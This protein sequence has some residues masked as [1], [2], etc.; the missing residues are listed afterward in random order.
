MTLDI[1]VTAANSICATA[2]PAPAAPF[3]LFPPLAFWAYATEDKA[4]NKKKTWTWIISFPFFLSRTLLCRS[5]VWT[6][7]IHNRRL[8]DDEEWLWF[9]AP[10]QFTHATNVLF[11]L[12]YTHTCVCVS[13]FFPSSDAVGPGE[14]LIFRAFRSNGHHLRTPSAPVLHNGRAFVYSTRFVF[15]FVEVE[16]IRR[17]VSLKEARDECVVAS[18]PSLFLSLFLFIVSLFL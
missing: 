2:S 10:S 6:G 4:R 8:A 9:E 1:N 7:R 16:D 18:K 13:L 12:L 15:V 11:S 3:S 17:F 14:I 5:V